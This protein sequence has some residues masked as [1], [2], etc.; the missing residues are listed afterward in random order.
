MPLHKDKRSHP[1][2][3]PYQHRQFDLNE[4]VENP[5]M[6]KT[7]REE[8]ESAIAKIT[9]LEARLDDEIKLN[10]KLKLEKQAFQL[11]LEDA[12][13]RVEKLNEEK[14]WALA[15]YGETKGELEVVQ[16]AYHTLQLEK[17]TV[18]HQLDEANRKLDEASQK[19]FIQYLV[20]IVA[21]VIL[22]FG[23][24][25]ATS[26]PSSWIGWMLVT[27]A[28]ILEV[29][30]FLITFLRSHFFTIFRKGKP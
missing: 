23:V 20:T 15:D 25:I 18:D 11:K 3:I 14:L 16:T 9:E 10:N 24:N 19:S 26:V 30:A 13:S 8:L 29:V 7:M 2:Y 1:T 4:Y 5:P 22:G 12:N 21:A 6:I 17:R 27:L 28:I